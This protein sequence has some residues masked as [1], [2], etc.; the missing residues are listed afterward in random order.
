MAKERLERLARM[1]L[2]FDGGDVCELK[3]CAHIL[4]QI[5]AEMRNLIMYV[6]EE[7]E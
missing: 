3:V 5:C 1:A 2:W 6:L 7:G 4:R